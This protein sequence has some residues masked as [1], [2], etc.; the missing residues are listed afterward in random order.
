MD[1][2]SGLQRRL[3]RGEVI[4]TEAA[5]VERMRHEFRIPA[6]DQLVYGGAIYDGHAREALR[7]I[8]GGYIEVA[9][10]LAMPLLLASSTRRSSPER[11][12]ASRFAGREV[13]GTGWPS[14]GRCAAAIAA[15]LYL[16]GLLGARGDAY[17][18]QEALP[19]REALAFH[20]AQCRAFLDGGADFLMAAT[21][22]ALSEALGLAAAMGETGLPFIISFVVDR[23]G[24]L[25]DGTPLGVAM[26]TID[27]I[28]PP[29]CLPGE[30]RPSRQFKKAGDAKMVRRLES[31]PVTLGAPLPAAYMKV[32]DAAMHRIGIGTTREMKSVVTGVFVPVWRTPDYTLRE[33][34]AI[35]RGKAFS[36]GILW[37]EF[38]ST[39]L[40][41]RVTELELPVYICQGKYD[42][43]TNHDLA[44]AYCAELRAPMKG[45]Y[46]FEHSAHSP[47]FE[48]PGRFRRILREDVL[49]GET[50]LA[51]ACQARRGRALPET[52]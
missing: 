7:Q 12:A 48:E 11:I 17:R 41:Q 51:D 37:D 39:D 25:L 24:L 30:L 34:V 40:T 10:R 9:R 29:L 49:A 44:R 36:R 26:A 14:C 27:D 15:T 6:D 21:L 32:R 35:W 13:M 47:A 3:S 1:G 42:F 45:F 20:R 18:P 52:S 46:T 38:Q 22:P 28:S 8:Y 31:A 16:G 33:K 5:V 2:A 19:P 50:G 23:S 43:T 4:L